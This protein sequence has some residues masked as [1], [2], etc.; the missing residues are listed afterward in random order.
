MIGRA[1][2]E[3]FVEAYSLEFERVELNEELLMD[4]AAASGGIYFR[5]G[6][7]AALPDSLRFES[8][9]SSLRREFELWNAPGVLIALVI[10]LAVEWTI[11]KKNRLL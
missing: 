3:F 7:A 8:R 5:L 9:E 10:L 11:R 2:G 4:L 6:D 1:E